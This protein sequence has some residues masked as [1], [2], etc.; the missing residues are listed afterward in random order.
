M[1]FVR[2]AEHSRAE[3]QIPSSQQLVKEK[4]PIRSKHVLI[5]NQDKKKS[6]H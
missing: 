1:N 3:Q 6:V 4:W 5:Y 2:K